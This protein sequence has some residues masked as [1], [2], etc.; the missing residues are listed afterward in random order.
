MSGSKN[1]ELTVKYVCTA[2]AATSLGFSS[3]VLVAYSTNPTKANRSVNPTTSS[4]QPRSSR[5]DQ[6][7]R[8]SR[9]NISA[10]GT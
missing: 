2:L 10:N 3:S 5:L 7:S 6:Y 8:L 4:R 1:T 9:Q